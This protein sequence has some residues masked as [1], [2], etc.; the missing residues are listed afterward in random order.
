MDRTELNKIVKEEQEWYLYYIYRKTFPFR[1]LWSWYKKDVI[2]CIAK[3][4]KYSRYAD[5]YSQL[6]KAK[7]SPFYRLM[8]YVYIRKRNK[9]ALKLCFEVETVNVQKGLKIL[10][11][12]AVINGKSKIGENLR[13]LGNN[14]VGN[15]GPNKLGCPTI[16]NNV[17]M[18]A[19]SMV[20]GDVFIADDIIIAAGAV[21]VS[22][23]TEKGIT[24]GGVPAKKLN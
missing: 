1:R 21:V 16:G 7:N 11:H 3:W 13:L 12:G 5:F 23:F 24:I 19:G 18:G 10:H 9:L 2:W 14:V 15:G 17:T 6:A 22:S 8:Q 20:V 4:Q